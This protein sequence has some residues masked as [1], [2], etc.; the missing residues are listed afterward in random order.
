MLHEC[1]CKIACAVG[2]EAYLEFDALKV[3]HEGAV[4]NATLGNYKVKHRRT[5]RYLGPTEEFHIRL[6]RAG[7]REVFR[8]DGVG[9]RYII[10]GKGTVSKLVGD[11]IFDSLVSR[12]KGHIPRHCL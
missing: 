7:K 9:R 2:V 4:A 12:H 1:R 5:A 8:L 6:D 3:R 10:Y 11:G